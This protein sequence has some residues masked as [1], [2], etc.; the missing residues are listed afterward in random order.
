MM[1]RIIAAA[2]MVSLLDAATT[3]IIIATGRGVEANPFLQFLNDV[4]EAVFFVQILGVLMLASLLKIFEILAAVLPTA[5]KTRVYGAATA[6][7]A[8]AVACRAAVVA[9]NML[10]IIVGITPLADALYA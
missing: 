4:P 1:R 5:L 6:V 8:A 9:N 2:F 7:F 3:Y 10:G